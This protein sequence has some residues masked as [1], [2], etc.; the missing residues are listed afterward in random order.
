LNSL[1]I[2]FE[3]VDAI[4]AKNIEGQ[5]QIPKG[6]IG[7]NLSHLK[8]YKKCLGSDKPILILEDDVQFSERVIEEI[9]KIE[10]P[11][12]W[13]LFY[14]GGNH[15]GLEL[16]MVSEN[17]HRLKRTFTTHCFAINPKYLEEI[18][19]KFSLSYEKFVIDEFLAYEIQTKYPC[20]GI[21]PSLAWQRGGFSDIQEISVNYDFLK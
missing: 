6:A 1:G 21:H 7:C 5:F 4:D 9:E 13:A 3:F 14:F 17:L 11:E 20:Y 8:I 18:I 12:D 15:N 19:E 2:E 10:I 16:N